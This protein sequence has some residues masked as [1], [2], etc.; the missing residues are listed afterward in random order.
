MGGKWGVIV[1]GA[2]Q[3]FGRSICM[4]LAGRL[5]AS[6][7]ESDFVLVSRNQEG[8]ALTVESMPEHGGVAHIVCADLSNMTAL[9][10]TAS[11][12]LGH[13]SLSDSEEDFDA[14]TAATDTATVAAVASSATATNTT[15]YDRIVLI[16]NA[17]SLGSVDKLA[18]DA[19]ADAAGVHAYFALNVS[20][21]LYLTS[22]IMRACHAA[23]NSPE[24]RLVNIS[25]LMA[26]QAFEGFGL[27]CAGKYA[28][29]AFFAVV[30]KEAAGT[31]ITDNK[32]VRCLNYAP[33]PLR[34]AMQTAIRTTHALPETRAMFEKTEADGR[35]LDC[36]QSSEKLVTLLIDDEFESGAHIDYFD[37]EEE[38]DVK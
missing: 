1:T 10:I 17:G 35:L 28:R 14:A 19:C 36:D 7:V 29:D 11:K 30:A 24:L 27:Y 21:V 15:P 12:I 5:A 13:L 22:R 26:V 3:G 33:G 9:P 37:L 32:S 34:T 16:H 25:S 4:R 18:A 2:S 6:G 8:M 20:H 38:E 31:G 23:A